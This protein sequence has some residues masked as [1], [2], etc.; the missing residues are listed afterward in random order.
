MS[1]TM[2]KRFDYYNYKNTKEFGRLSEKERSIL[3]MKFQYN[4]S[5]KEIAEKFD[6]KSAMRI[7]QIVDGAIEEVERLFKA[8][9]YSDVLDIPVEYSTMPKRIRNHASYVIT[10]YYKREKVYYTLKDLKYLIESGT[11]YNVR[12]I[13]EK[14]IQ[15]AIIVFAEDYGIQVNIK[16]M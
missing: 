13:G 12:N 10:N 3:E 4:Y 9:E 15:E 2:K 1:G 8:R 14:A 7:K 6:L 11:I 5:Y 16:E